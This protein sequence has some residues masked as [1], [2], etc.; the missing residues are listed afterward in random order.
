[1]TAFGGGQ[2]AGTVKI[3]S[4][5]TNSPIT[6][7]VTGANFSAAGGS[8]TTTSLARPRLW[9]KAFKLRDDAPANH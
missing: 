9:G 1:M 8:G 2:L 7:K 4:D 5:A 3:V 6:V